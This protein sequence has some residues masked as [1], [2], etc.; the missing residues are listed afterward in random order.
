MHLL[1]QQPDML[2]AGRTRVNDHSR[3]I[4]CIHTT[5]P[6]MPLRGLGEVGVA[7]RSPGVRRLRLAAR[8]TP[9]GTPGYP[10]PQNRDFL[11]SK[12]IEPTGF[13]PPRLPDSAPPARFATRPQGDTRPH[14]RPAARMLERVDAVVG[15]VLA[16]LIYA[17]H[18]GALKVG[19]VRDAC[20]HDR[21]VGVTC[22]KARVPGREENLGPE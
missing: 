1:V 17:L 16:V 19:E 2:A 6:R 4:P 3:Q 22:A 12:D 21:L 5:C 11:G 14:G 9:R 15:F 13:A 7:G 20:R 18:L 8:L 10:D